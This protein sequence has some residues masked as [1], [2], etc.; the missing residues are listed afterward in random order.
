MQVQPDDITHLVD[1]LR[2]FRLFERFSSVWLKAK[3]VPDAMN[4]VLSHASCHR[5]AAGAPVRCVLWFCLQSSDDNVLNL[6]VR[7]LA[8]SAR[9]W[10]IY[11]APQTFIDKA[12]TSLSDG[13]ISRLQLL[14][15]RSIRHAIRTREHNPASKRKSLRSLPSVC[16][17][18]QSVLLFDREHQ[19]CQPAC[20]LTP[21]RNEFDVQYSSA[22][23]AQANLK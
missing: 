10:F 15:H 1:E 18:R 6:L 5:H 9:S 19:L 8:W 20:H 4:R 22:N 17:S 21:P 14:R 11:Q 3:C 2:I 16:P 13:R 23:L 12:S 7:D